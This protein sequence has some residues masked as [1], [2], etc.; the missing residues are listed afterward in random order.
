MRRLTAAIA[1]T[2]VVATFVT[3]CGSSTKNTAS[4]GSGTVKLE[5]D[6]FYFKPTDVKLDAGKATTLEVENEGK[7]EHNLTI[8][9]LKV[10]KDL[11]AGKTT[12]ISLTSKAGTYTFHCEY[13]PSQMKGTITVG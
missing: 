13:H 7:V 11:E 9:G 5:A 2:L 3:G 4:G 1:A 8:E 10:D 6:D 12:K